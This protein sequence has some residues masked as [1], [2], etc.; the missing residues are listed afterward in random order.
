MLSDVLNAF[1]VQELVSILMPFAVRKT[2]HS[3]LPCKTFHV[4]FIPAFFFSLFAA[5]A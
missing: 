3:L 1:F 4:F 2:V 5:F